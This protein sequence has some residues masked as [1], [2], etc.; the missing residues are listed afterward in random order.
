MRHLEGLPTCTVNGMGSQATVPS[1]ETAQSLPMQKRS[2]CH[3]RL[4][5]RTG[6]WLSD[7]L[8]IA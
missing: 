3:P 5:W 4:S 2:A 6:F 8:G 7:R 1:V